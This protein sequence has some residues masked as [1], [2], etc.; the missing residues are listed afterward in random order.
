MGITRL[1]QSIQGN[2]C[3]NPALLTKTLFIS[4]SIPAQLILLYT[5]VAG[6]NT[7]ITTA[8]YAIMR[9]GIILNRCFNNKGL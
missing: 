2:Q 6:A 5:V 4:I 1:S 7:G 8:A 9:A 3:R